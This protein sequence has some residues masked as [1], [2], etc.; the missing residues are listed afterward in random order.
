VGFKK[1]LEKGPDGNGWS[2]TPD[3]IEGTRRR[4]EEALELLTGQPAS[5]MGI[6]A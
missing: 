2:M 6:S 4:Y 1:G 5:S 3:V